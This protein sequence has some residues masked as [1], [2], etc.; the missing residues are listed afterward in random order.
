M[1]INDSAPA[2]ARQQ[3]LINA[4]P[5]K[6][7]QL[8]SDI[9]HW[10]AWQPGISSAVL[11]GALIPGSIFRWKSGGTRIVSQ[12]QEVEPHRRLGWTGKAMGAIAKHLWI[13][14]PQNGGV[15]VRTEESFEGW[16][17]V[18]LRGMMQKT[19]DTSLQAWLA[20]LKKTAESIA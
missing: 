9:N 10:S 4:S 20:Q 6:V 3:V 12:L 16:V 8:L 5:E 14:E 1:E 17:V 18:L 2:L 7:W 15:L 13:L 11:D 19:L